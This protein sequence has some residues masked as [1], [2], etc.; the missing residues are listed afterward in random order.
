MRITAPLLA[1]VTAVVVA[2]PAAAQDDLITLG[3]FVTVRSANVPQFEEQVREHTQWHARQND[4]QSWVTYQALTGH[5]EYAVL[6]PGMTWASMDA[7][8]LDMGTD[9]AHWAESAAQYVETE[10]FV[11]WAAIPGGNQPEDTGQFPIIQVFEFEINSGGQAAVMNAIER[12][13]EALADTDI[14]FQWSGVVS[15][16]GPP[17]VFLALWFRSFAELGT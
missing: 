3:A 1:A 6:A 5:G 9:I 4:P 12:V 7:P 2:M 10:D 17:S 15:R 14:H 8:A 13:N 16:D 11:M